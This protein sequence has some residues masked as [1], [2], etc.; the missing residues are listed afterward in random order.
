LLLE[1]RRVGVGA[2]EAPISDV[3]RAAFTPA[4]R[5]FPDRMQIRVNENL[6]NA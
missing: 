3:G 1:V 6:L 5:I 2:F 4:S